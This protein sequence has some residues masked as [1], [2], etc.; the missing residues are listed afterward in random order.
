MGYGLEGPSVSSRNLKP[1]TYISAMPPT[2]CS[3]I[4]LD[5]R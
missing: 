5:D 3:C 1:A 4:P 2:P